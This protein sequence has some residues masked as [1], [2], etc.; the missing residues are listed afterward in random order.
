MMSTVGHNTCDIQRRSLNPAERSE[1]DRVN[2]AYSLHYEAMNKVVVKSGA[3][4]QGSS[5]GKVVA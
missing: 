5:R 3:G 2:G 4:A 1:V